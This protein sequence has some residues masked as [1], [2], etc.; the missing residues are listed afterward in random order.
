V[1]IAG[2]VVDTMSVVVQEGNQFA[3]ALTAGSG[4][5]AFLVYQGWAGTADDKTYNNYRIWSKADPIPGIEEASGVP[6]PSS[7]PVPTVVRGVLF[8][9]GDRGPETG[10]RTALM[11][12]SGREV[13]VLSPGANDLR[14]L[15]SGVYFVRGEGRGAGDVGPIRKVVVTR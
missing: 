1:S 9:P 3:P 11:D 7:K 10:D 2:E 15:A 13:L 8:L 5:P 12:V 6:A 4:S 14:A